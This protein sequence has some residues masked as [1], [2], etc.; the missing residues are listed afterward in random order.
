MPCLQDVSCINLNEFLI[1]IL[2]QNAEFY[3][4][5]FCLKTMDTTFFKWLFLFDKF[6]NFCLCIK[7][8]LKTFTCRM[9][10]LSTNKRTILR[11]VRRFLKDICLSC[12]VRLFFLQCSFFVDKSNLKNDFRLQ[13]VKGQHHM[14]QY[15]KHAS[16]DSWDLKTKSSLT[17]LCF[18]PG[19]TYRCGEEQTQLWFVPLFL[20]MSLLTRPSFQLLSMSSKQR[21]TGV[22][23]KYANDFDSDRKTATCGFLV[24]LQ[25]E[26]KMTLCFKMVTIPAIFFTCALLTWK[27]VQ[28]SW[29]W[30]NHFHNS[31][32]TVYSAHW[33]INAAW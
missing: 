12:P 19:N 26:D 7:N 21:A 13:R 22:C 10:I 17:W 14:N 23:L 2:L 28:S 11:F 29:P 3:S 18:F 5:C 4:N 30:G 15:T 8:V 32:N 6:V 31:H 9:S 16:C 27:T 33:K 20:M 1:S 25:A 24:I